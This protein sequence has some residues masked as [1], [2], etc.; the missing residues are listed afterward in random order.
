MKHS[1]RVFT[2]HQIVG[3]SPQS[4][5][6]RHGSCLTLTKN[7]F[8][9]PQQVS[10][11]CWETFFGKLTD[12]LYPFKHLLVRWMFCLMSHHDAKIWIECFFKFAWIML[13]Y[14]GQLFIFKLFVGDINQFCQEKHWKNKY[15]ATRWHCGVTSWNHLRERKYIRDQAFGTFAWVTLSITDHFSVT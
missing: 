14:S 8:T 3:R 2:I 11:H 5:T 15:C 1:F 7:M 6:V 4:C 9:N 12:E 13:Y 10:C